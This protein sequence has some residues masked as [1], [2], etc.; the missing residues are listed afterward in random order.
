MQLVVR[1]CYFDLV[2][3][4]WWK[5]DSKFYTVQGMARSF[6][7]LSGRSNSLSIT[8]GGEKLCCLIGSCVTIN[9]R[10]VT[11]NNRIVSIFSLYKYLMQL[12]FFIFL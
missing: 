2:Y 6:R 9:N 10:H 3:S 8:S 12:Y 1:L 4:V 7:F 11:I 5:I